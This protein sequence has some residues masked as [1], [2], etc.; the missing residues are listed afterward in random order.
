M[1]CG[2]S[3]V[4]AGALVS[5]K[6]GSS[7][8]DNLRIA[9]KAP[10]TEPRSEASAPAKAERMASGVGVDREPGRR[11]DVVGLLEQ[12]GPQGHSLL[13]G[14]L[15]VIDVQVKV[16]LLRRP[17]RPGRR[18]MV[19]GKLESHSRLTVDVDGVPVVVGL[20]RTAQQ[21]GPESALGR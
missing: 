14:G 8:F 13:M 18:D 17:L 3:G 12:P 15:N 9:D 5:A 11:L 1:P 7:A 2:R 19:W 10:I 6:R 16:D 21:S 4:S 20:G